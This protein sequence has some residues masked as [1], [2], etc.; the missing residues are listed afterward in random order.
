M[1]R[2]AAI[3]I[4]GL[5]LGG[6]ETAGCSEWISANRD[7]TRWSRMARHIASRVPMMKE[8]LGAKTAGSSFDITWTTSSTGSS[9]WGS[10]SGES[11]KGHTA[12]TRIPTRGREAE[13][14]RK[15]T[16]GVDSL[17]WHVKRGRLPDLPMQRVRDS[18][19]LPTGI[20]VR[21]TERTSHA[22]T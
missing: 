9:T 8:S 20:P 12:S 19:G 7:C 4:A 1:F 10:P 11:S 13:R 21:R 16:W 17:S 6:C 3:A 18:R 5:C 15:R 22:N 14:T 2:I